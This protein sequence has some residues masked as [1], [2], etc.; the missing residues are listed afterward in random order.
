MTET[1]LV[2]LERLVKFMFAAEDWLR[3]TWI[4]TRLRRNLSTIGS[5]RTPHPEKILFCILH[6][7]LLD[8]SLYIGKV[9]EIGCIV[10]E[11]LGAICQMALWN[12]PEERM[13]KSKLGDSE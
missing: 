9:F 12:A 2:P 3:V 8:R 10:P 7:D 11:I 1:S 4:R 13:T 6:M 5:V